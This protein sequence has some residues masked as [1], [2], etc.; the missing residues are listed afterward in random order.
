MATIPI[1][2]RP[3]RERDALA[4]SN[5]QERA[6][7]SAYQGLLPAAALARHA[8]EHDGRWWQ[9][10]VRRGGVIVLDFDGFIAGYAVAGPIRRRIL[11]ADGEIFEFYL[12]PA[13]QG[14][15]LGTRLFK[16]TRQQLRRHGLKSLAVWALD[17]N[18][19][20]GAFYR[21][22]GGQPFA[23]RGMPFGGESFPATAYIW[24]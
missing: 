9:R 6:W 17:V 2:I 14:V 20:A 3:A 7:R 13:H 8:A 18:D 1:D 23:R 12:D 22:M 5:L 11:P 4:I 21:A 15:G 19:R 24:R 10:A 16:E